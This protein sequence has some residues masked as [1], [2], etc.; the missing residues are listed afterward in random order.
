MDQQIKKVFHTALVLVP[1]KQCID[2]IQLL[3]KQYDKAYERWMPHVNLCFPFADPA[4]FEQVFQALQNH[5]KDFPAFQVRLREFNHFQHGK[6][7]VMWLNPES[8]NDGIQKLYQ[9][10]LK[11]Y[12][13][14][15]DLN[16]KSEHGFQPHITIGQFGTNQIEQRKKAFQPQFQE[17]QFQCQEI[18]MIS[19]NGQDDPFQIMH[20]IKFKTE[21]PQAYE[22]PG[23]K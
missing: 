9:E 7:C 16:K 8:E 18:H 19:R 3:R 23:Q 21:N 15:D 14:L 11:V 6:N 10:I 20:T 2:Q 5:L 17:V 12:P 4:Q 22:Y 13:Q 1:P